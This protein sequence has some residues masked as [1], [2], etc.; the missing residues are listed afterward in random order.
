MLVVNL[1]T[2]VEM[3]ISRAPLGRLAVV[4]L[5]DI[6][7]LVVDLGVLLVDVDP[8]VLVVDPGVLVVD[9]GVRVD[10][11]EDVVP[12][13]CKLSMV[14]PTLC[15]DVTGSVRVVASD[16]VEGDAEG[17]GRLDGVVENA[18][19]EVGDLGDCVEI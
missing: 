12:T 4:L 18:D 10:D 1:E 19:T 3:G 6:G 17:T 16:T 2:E 7:V 13:F 9:L 15:D 5:V 8:G 11:S 14:L